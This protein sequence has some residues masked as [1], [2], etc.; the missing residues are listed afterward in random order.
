MAIDRDALA[1]EIVTF[2]RTKLRAD[3]AGVDL[4]TPLV[5]TGVVDSVALVRLA[6]FVEQRTGLRIPDRDVTVEHFD[7]L[8]QILA[9]V[10]RR[11]GRTA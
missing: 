9:Y 11:Q 1:G 2:L 7:S 10:E 5:S 6:S 8:A 3:T 4:D